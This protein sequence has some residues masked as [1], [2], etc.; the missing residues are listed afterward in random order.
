M[1]RAL[2]LALLRGALGG[3]TG[4]PTAEQLQ[5]LLA[6]AE[7]QLFLRRSEISDDLLDTA[8]YLHSVASVSQARE[9]YTLARQ[10]DAFAVSA[11][12]FDLALQGEGRWSRAERLTFGF[13]A[14]IGYRR[15]G[16]DPNATAVSHFHPAWGLAS[17]WCSARM[18]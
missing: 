18:A 3:R 2:D 7:T 5:D 6:N 15:G 16:Q 11:H 17:M 9:R 13:A 8:W 14:A 1:E 10:R 12:I 4:L